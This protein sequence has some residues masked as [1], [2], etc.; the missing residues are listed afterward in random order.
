M[1][2]KHN[3]PLS[4]LLLGDSS[5]LNKRRI[6]LNLTS[7]LQIHNS[8]AKANSKLISN[9]R[10]ELPIRLQLQALCRHRALRLRAIAPLARGFHLI[11]AL[12]SRATEIV[13]HQRVARSP[14][15]YL[16][17]H[18][19]S[20]RQAAFLQWAV[21]FFHRYG[22]QHTTA[23]PQI[24]GTRYHQFPHSRIYAEYTRTILLRFCGGCKRTTVTQSTQC[25][26]NTGKG[27]SRAR[28]LLISKRYY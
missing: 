8:Q 14:S 2:P 28:R 9:D 13:T 11:P 23:I 22:R 1:M 27:A 20:A 21:L 17:F 16:L 12:Q 24:A 18:C 10:K 26:I 15:I 3:G 25:S 4:L 7:L 19:L 6:S 5:R